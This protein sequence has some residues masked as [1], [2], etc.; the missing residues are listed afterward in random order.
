[1]RHI[2]KTFEAH[3]ADPRLPRTLAPKLRDAGFHITHQDVYT[4]LNP[5]YNENQIIKVENVDLTEE[6]N[7]P[8]ELEDMVERLDPEEEAG[9]L[10]TAVEVC[11]SSACMGEPHCEQVLAVSGFSALQRGQGIC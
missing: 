2:L 11:G 5:E 8:T 7:Q 6:L 10:G 9:S 3:C 1:M 4:V